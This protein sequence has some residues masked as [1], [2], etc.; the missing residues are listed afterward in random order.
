ME[1]KKPQ[2]IPTFL[3]ELC[4]FITNNK[5]DYGRH[6]A[7]LKHISQCGGNGWN[8]KNPQKT[9]DFECM[10]GKIYKHSSGLWKHKK[11]CNATE[12]TSNN[13]DPTD[14]QLI[15]LLLKENK[16]FKELIIEQSGKMLELANKPSSITNN[17]NCTSQQFNLNLFLNEKCKNAMNMSDFVDSLEILE[18]DFEDIGKLG[19][20]QGISNI[21]IKG[22]KDLDETTRPLHCNDRKRE[23]LYIKENDT[24]NKDD[25]NQKF[26]K[27]IQEVSHKNVKY[28]PVWRD[29]HPDA[30]DGTTKK[31]SQYMRIVN[32]V[33]TSISPDDRVGINKIIS[34]VANKVYIDKGAIC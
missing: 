7:T 2:K 3:C 6:L 28:I 32:Q 33:M 19:Y 8:A 18:D 15:M 12:P 17:N 16:E 29:A 1:Q 27:A 10:C 22:L 13:G 26:I 31:N 30:L 34:N 11:K 24:W 20:I 23:T 4:N 14:K 25:N 5:K 21:F 9:P